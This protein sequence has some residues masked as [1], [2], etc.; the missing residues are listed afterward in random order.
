MPGEAQVYEAEDGSTWL[1]W[2]PRRWRGW[3][4][5]EVGFTEK[6]DRWMREHHPEVLDAAASPRA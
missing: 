3:I 4:P 2:P 6:S 1:R 5:G